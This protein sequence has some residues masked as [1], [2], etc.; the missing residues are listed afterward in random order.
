MFDTG[1]TISAGDTDLF[2]AEAG[3]PDAP[4]IVLLHGGMGSRDDFLP[5]ARLLAP[6]HRLIAIDSRGHGRSGLGM[7]AMTY[8]Q[9]TEDIAEVLDGLDLTEAGIIGHSDGGIVAL[10]LAASDAVQPR[11][12]VAVGAHWHLPKD[13]PLREVF[14]A[15]TVEKWRSRFPECVRQYQ[16]ENPAPDFPRLF[17]A[18]IEMWLGSGED[19][20]PGSTIRDITSPL[21]VIRGDDDIFVSRAQAIEL[22]EQVDGARL[23]NL[24]YASH[25]VLEDSPEDVLPALTRFIRAAQSGAAGL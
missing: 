1:K 8:R 14:A 7:S 15:M 10:R 11:F 23:L 12:V 2:V 20:Y 5:L 24:P 6:D 25:S 18:V 21:L 13:D 19:A 3:R 22:A 9:L 16:A 4:P 17:D